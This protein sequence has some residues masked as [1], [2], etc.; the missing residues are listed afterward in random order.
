MSKTQFGLI[1]QNMANFPRTKQKKSQYFMFQY[2]QKTER[3]EG[4]GEFAL[5]CMSPADL[6]RLFE[7]VNGNPAPMGTCP[8][9]DGHAAAKV[10]QVLKDEI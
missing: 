5:M 9:G 2:T 3:E 10:Y 1:V 6:E 4:V 8:Y 7:D